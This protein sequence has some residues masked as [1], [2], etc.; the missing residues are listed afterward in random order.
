MLDQK[1]LLL[2]LQAH[3]HLQQLLQKAVGL[4]VIGRHQME[5]MV[6]QEVLA[7]VV[8]QVLVHQQ[9]ELVGLHQLLLQVKATQV[10]AVQVLLV[11]RLL[12]V[13]V[14]EQVPAKQEEP[15]LAQQVAMVVMALLLVL[16]SVEE[17]MLVAAGVR[18][19]L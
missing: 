14:V 1:E 3:P 9:Q 17:L 12:V 8:G 4:V 13:E 18:A 7:E 11:V 2:L 6:V 5:L 16:L 10:V 15:V 19:I